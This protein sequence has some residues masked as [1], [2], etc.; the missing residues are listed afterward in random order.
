MKRVCAKK[1]DVLW[2]ILSAPSQTLLIEHGELTVAAV[3]SALASGVGGPA[4]SRGAILFIVAIL[5]LLL[6]DNDI[7]WAQHPEHPEGHHRWVLFIRRNRKIISKLEQQGSY[8][9]TVERMRCLGV[10]SAIS[11]APSGTRA[12]ENKLT[13][14]SREYQRRRSLSLTGFNHSPLQHVRR[15][16]ILPCIVIGRSR[17]S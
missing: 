16:F 13:K 10:L 1:H 15:S 11:R 8:K 6:L 17:R 5:S 9:R 3:I 7:P 4:K 2:F 14:A 12:R